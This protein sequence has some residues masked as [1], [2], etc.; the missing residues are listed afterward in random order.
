MMWGQHERRADSGSALYQAEWSRELFQ[1][2]HF[3]RSCICRDGFSC[4]D[5]AV[6]CSFSTGHNDKGCCLIQRLV[7]PCETRQN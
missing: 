1:H 5:V 4:R 3:G 2:R 6:H 7:T